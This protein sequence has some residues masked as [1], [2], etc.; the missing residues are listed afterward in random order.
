MQ[1]YS[2]EDLIVWYMA[3]IL[4]LQDEIVL[5]LVTHGQHKSK[6]LKGHAS[7]LKR[8]WW[9][10]KTYVSWLLGTLMKFNWDS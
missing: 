6:F 4:Y 8:L 9:Y 2:K 3:L 5:T 7:V 1:S 10:N